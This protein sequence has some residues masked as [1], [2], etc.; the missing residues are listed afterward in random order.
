MFE[1]MRTKNY[2]LGLPLLAA[3]SVVVGLLL[4][5]LVLSLAPVAGFA[6]I[7]AAGIAVVVALEVIS[8][9]QR[10]R[11][12]P[13]EPGQDPLALRYGRRKVRSRRT[14]SSEDDLVESEAEL[15]YDGSFQ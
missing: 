13:H 14:P 10:R 5:G 7:F 2:L 4:S 9:Y 1:R 6:V 12:H 15:I 11:R 8:R 3:V